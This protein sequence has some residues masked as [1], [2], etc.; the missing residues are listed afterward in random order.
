MVGVENATP[1][2]LVLL[3]LT[4]LFI[5]RYI[6]SAKVAAKTDSPLYI[7]RLG[8]VDAIEEATGR[9]AELGRPIVFSTGLT[10]V[11]PVLQACIGILKHVARKTARYK[12][13]LFVPQNDSAV[14]AI[15][16][17]TVSEAYRLEGKS[18][19]LD[20]RTIQFL[21]EEQFAFAAGYMGL[22]QREEAASTFLFGVFAAESLILAEAGQQVGAMQIASSV[23]PEQVPFFICTC[24]YTLIGEELFG[25]SAYL[26]REPV[27]VGTL[28][29]QDRIKLI[30]LF[31]IVLGVAVSTFNSF[32]DTNQQLPLP[33]IL[34]SSSW[35]NLQQ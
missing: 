8:G 9:A 30:F 28:L 22:V 29:A 20:P 18:S 13:K 19:A 23:S 1:G 21:S 17:D 35:N 31:F 16:A 11:G 6:R 10:G 24:D 7:R 2:I 32:R 15:T 4:L 34:L 3:I 5:F 27:Q 14:M 25:A 33:T 12:C 26:T